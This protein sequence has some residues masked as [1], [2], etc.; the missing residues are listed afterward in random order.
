LYQ[1]GHLQFTI[2]HFREE[3]DGFGDMDEDVVPQKE[4]SQL[5][6]KNNME[7]SEAKK[8]KLYVLNLMQSKGGKNTV[9]K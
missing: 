9:I 3:D 4:S 2:S 1:L 6:E 7:G 8:R 5:K